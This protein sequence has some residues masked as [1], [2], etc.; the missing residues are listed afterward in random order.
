M[1]ALG[2]MLNTK[3]SLKQYSLQTSI[4]LTYLTGKNFLDSNATG[5]IIYRPKREDQAQNRSYQPR[6]NN[7]TNQLHKM[8]TLN[9]PRE[10]QCKK[11]Q[12]NM[13]NQGQVKNKK[14]VSNITKTYVPDKSRNRDMRTSIQGLSNFLF[15][16]GGKL[17]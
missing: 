8:N 9:P 11:H 2:Y 15:R 3:T 17:L 16:R 4:H 6:L 7:K 1:Y 13:K 12:L 5:H 14:Q 10:M